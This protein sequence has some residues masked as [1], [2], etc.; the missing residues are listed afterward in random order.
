MN[1]FW[2]KVADWVGSIAKPWHIFFIV[3]LGSGAFL[4]DL[5]GISTHFGLVDQVASFKLLFA[6]TF[7]V[8]SAI[9]ALNLLL[10]L[11]GWASGRIRRIA[12]NVSASR[13]DLS[14]E[15]RVIL[16]F[17]HSC[18]PDYVQLLREHPSVRELRRHNFIESHPAVISTTEYSRYILTEAGMSAL[19]NSDIARFS[20]LPE[21]DQIQF[22]Q[23][24]SGLTIQRY[25]TRS[26]S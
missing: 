25:Q 15:A 6:I 26:W 9:L 20:K 19:T 3:A 14:I 1:G 10:N 23:E 7:W 13:V 2:D 24:V 21:N 16:G 11:L 18:A 4:T 22:L 5:F 12:K 8:S 17:V